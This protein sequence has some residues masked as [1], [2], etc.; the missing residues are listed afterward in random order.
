M[1]KFLLIL[2]AV[3]TGI[4]LYVYLDPRLSRQLVNTVREALPDQSPSSQVY[5]WRDAS[6]RW[7]IT[8]RPPAGDVPYELL[9]YDHDANLIPAEALTGRQ[10]E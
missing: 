10:A 1:K 9:E 5:K 7:Q 8:D 6:G 2:A 3:L 4:G